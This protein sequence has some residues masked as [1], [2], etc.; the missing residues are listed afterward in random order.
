MD[1]SGER[2]FSK[3]PAEPQAQQK[4]L[5]K[6]AREPAVAVLERVDREEYNDEN[7]DQYQGMLAVLLYGLIEPLDE[8]LHPSGRLKGCGGLKHHA[9]TL[10]VRAECLDMVGTFLY[11]PRCCSS[12]VL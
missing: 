10:A 4:Q 6:D 3:Q 5:R 7:P 12:L 11:W 1:W 2:A 9:Q 8:I